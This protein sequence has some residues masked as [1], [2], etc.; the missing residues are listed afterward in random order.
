MLICRNFVGECVAV[1]IVLV[2]DGGN[3]AV[4]NNTRMP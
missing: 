2:V 3:V 4:V 1:A